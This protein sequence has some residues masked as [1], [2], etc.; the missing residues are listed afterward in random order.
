MEEGGEH[1]EERQRYNKMKR[2]RRR[3][4]WKGK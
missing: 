1:N 4:K 2:K 3:S